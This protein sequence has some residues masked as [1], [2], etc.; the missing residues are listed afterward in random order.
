MKKFVLLSLIL[1]ISIVL[2]ACGDT[3]DQEGT[4]TLR[5]AHVGSETHQYQIAAEKFKEIIENETNGAVQIEIYHSGV[6][7]GEGE[8]VEQVLDGTL[9]ITSVVAD[10]AFANTVP[11]MNVFGLPYLF[12][13]LDHVYQTLDGEVGQDL[14]E[15]AN[16]RGMKALGFWEIGFRHITND[17][18]EV[19]TPEDMKGLSIRVQPSPVW[20]AHMTALGANATPMD[21]NELYSAMD[22]G[23]VDGQEN[24]LNTIYS[25]KFHEVQQYVSLTGH[26]YSPG[27]VVMSEKAWAS[28]TDEQQNIV[29]NAME[30]AKV[31]QRATLSDINEKI[32]ADLE[33]Y[34]TT[35]THPDLDAFAEATKD[36]KDVLTEQ[37]PPELIERI[38]NVQ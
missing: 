24:P 3:T 7:G 10:S 15:K 35:V 30:E 29:E 5:L 23:T 17:V 33:E 27:I 8:A 6:L 28:L 34:G 9:D 21:F 13:D 25:M 20:E 11:E 22:Q 31:Y 14:L 4:M 26:N 19:S 37:V 38:E 16:Q 32:I 12:R 2:S 1:S 18:R 36:V